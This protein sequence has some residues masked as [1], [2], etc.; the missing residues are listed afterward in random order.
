MSGEYKGFRVADRSYRLM[1]NQVFGWRLEKYASLGI[2]PEEILLFL[3]DLYVNVK[4][5]FEMRYWLQDTI[6]GVLQLGQGIEKWV[7]L[8]F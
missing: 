3:L 2:K 1:M 7:L 5:N 4:P 8:A 6:A